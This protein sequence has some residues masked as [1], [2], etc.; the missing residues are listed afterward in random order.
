[1]TGA[2]AEGRPRIVLGLL[3][4]PGM[5]AEMAEQLAPELAARLNEL[6]PGV[7]WDVPVIPDG[8]VE[9]PALTGDLIDAA[10]QRLL[11]EDWELA[12]AITD[13]PLRVGRRPVEGQASPTHRVA[14][15]SLPALGPARLRRRA[16]DAAVG[17]VAAVLGDRD[18]QQR[19]VDLAELADENPEDAPT[20]LAALA[21]GGNLRLLAGMVRANR[22]WRLAARLYRALVAAVAA[23]AFGL[24]TGDVWRISAS[25]SAVRLIAITVLAIGL[26]VTS[27]IVVHGLWERGGGGRAPDQVTLFNAATTATVLLGVLSLYAALWVLTLAGAGLVITPDTLAVALG[28]PAHLSDY[29]SLA[30]FASSLATVGGAL[31]AGLES[32]EAVREAAYAYRPADPPAAAVETEAGVPARR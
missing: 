27:L 9:P 10:H 5:A 1:M 30:W 28:R 25:L 23:V 3:A 14:V 21:R 26:T 2:D 17:L 11:R 31:G 32:D 22:P 4:A 13:L 6:Y 19:L 20:G 15:L 16:L 18:T 8:L 24:V 7:E 12:L 29:L